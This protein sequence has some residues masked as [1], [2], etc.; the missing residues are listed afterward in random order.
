ML[1]VAFKPL[2][3]RKETNFPPLILKIDDKLLNTQVFQFK[4]Q[5]HHYFKPYISPFI[6]E[7]NLKL[8]SK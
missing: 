2:D 1:F 6:N 8:S 7:Q 5:V 3:P 4:Q